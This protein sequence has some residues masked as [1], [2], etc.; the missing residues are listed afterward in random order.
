MPMGRDLAAVE[1][2]KVFWKISTIAFRLGPCFLRKAL[3][4]SSPSS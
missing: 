1:A 3:R 4:N 2:A